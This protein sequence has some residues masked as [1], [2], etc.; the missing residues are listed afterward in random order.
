MINLE[1]QFP[2]YKILL[3]EHIRHSESF[4]TTETKKKKT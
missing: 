1:V 2:L 3:Y 4:T